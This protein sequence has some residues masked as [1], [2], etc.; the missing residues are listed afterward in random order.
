MRK[1]SAESPGRKHKYLPAGDALITR[2]PEHRV[3]RKSRPIIYPDVP[4]RPGDIPVAAL[5]SQETL[6][7]TVRA[8]KVPD[9]PVVLLPVGDGGAAG[10]V[11]LQRLR[12]SPVQPVHPWGRLV[13]AEDLRLPVV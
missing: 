9:Q 10:A 12:R 3:S 7:G 4:G 5:G 1:R 2:L 13:D 8:G 6:L 11:E